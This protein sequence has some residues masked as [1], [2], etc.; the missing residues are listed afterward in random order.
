MDRK[1]CA[2]PDPHSVSE[3][4]HRI[5]RF[6]PSQN[7]L[8]AISW[9]IFEKRDLILIART[10]FGKSLVCEQRVNA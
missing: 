7:Q 9:L 6:E 2:P 10:G 1:I 3:Q 4:L 5:F 8:R